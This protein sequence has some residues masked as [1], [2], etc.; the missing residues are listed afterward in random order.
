MKDLYSLPMTGVVWSKCGGNTGDSNTDESCA[1]VAEI[2]GI[3]G[4]IAIQDTKNPTAGEL[5]FDAAETRS[6]AER[7]S[8]IAA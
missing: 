5:R 1:L 8:K 2:P 6:L 4:A 3:P 7:I